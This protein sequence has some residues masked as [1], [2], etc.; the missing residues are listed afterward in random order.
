MDDLIGKVERWRQAGVL[1]SATAERILEF[2]GVSAV[3]DVPEDGDRPGAIEAF[4]YLGI[5]VLG[6]GVFSIAG[7]EWE[8]LE[9]WARVA[10]VGLP[11]VVA[12]LLGAG[13]RVF[14]EPAVRRGGQLAW[15]VSAGMAT[16]LVVVV[17]EEYGPGADDPGARVT[18]GVLGL[19]YAAVLWALWPTHLQVLAMA[20]VG[21]FFGQMLGSWPD[22]FDQ[23]LAGA[24]LVVFAAIG[25]LLAEKGRIHP[26]ASARLAF[27]AV[28]V[29]GALEMQVDS[30][31][32]WEPF[33]LVAGIALVGASIHRGAFA[34]MAVGMAGIFLALIIGVQEHLADELG[35]QLA[36]T[37]TGVIILAGVLLVAQLR[38]SF[39]WGRR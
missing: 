37:L 32:Q 22:D 11:A 24:S 3:A 38:K 16:A 2:E 28:L 31:W 6:I 25:L 35:A 26:L 30:S 34:F 15:L 21:V 14:S 29:I 8:G 23:R 33:G 20:G 10:L 39:S 1:D 19:G 13:M 9:S 12:L 7:S 27:A 5:L 17:A 36:F 4:L 18:A